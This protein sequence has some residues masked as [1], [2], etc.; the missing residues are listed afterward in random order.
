MK[1]KLP[2]PEEYYRLTRARELRRKAARS[3]GR[4]NA[5]LL[6][7][8]LFNS[9]TV[10]TRE[11]VQHLHL[12]VTPGWLLTAILIVCMPLGFLLIP[13]WNRIGR[14]RVEADR[15]EAEHQARY[16]ELRA[17]EEH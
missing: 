3:Q 15:L 7:W 2:V 12:A 17:G 11:L 13:Y 5:W 8:T 16:G 6:A 10:L 4:W 1:T 9:V 14:W